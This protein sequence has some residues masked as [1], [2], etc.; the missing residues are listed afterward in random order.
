MSI[1]DVLLKDLLRKA[2]EKCYEKDMTLIERGMEQA[3]V[4]R[5][6]YY[7]QNFIDYDEMYAR[8]K[9]YDLDCEYNKNGEHTK[10]TQRCK[11][12]TKPD[13]TMHKRKS[14][15][16]N[17][18]VVEF[19]SRKSKGKKW[20]GTSKYMDEVKLEDYTLPEIYNYQLGVWVKL[21][22]NRPIF[23]F[24]KNGEQQ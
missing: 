22:K 1:S 9:A 2:V 18:L 21:N 3:S 24:F 19:K 23:T 13:M 14:N 4:A 7:M 8:L 17:L 12:G 11:N 20:N 6:F 10:A 15:E 5:I 16:K